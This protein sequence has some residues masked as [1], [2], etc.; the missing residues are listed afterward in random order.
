[1]IVERNPPLSRD[2]LNE[3]QLQMLKQ[4]EI[5]GLL[6]L[7]TEQCDG[8]LSLRYTLTGSKMLSEAIRVSNWS[9]TEMM[10]AL[11]RLAEVLEECRLYLLDADRIR[12]LD[13]FIFIGD[14]WQDLRFTYIPIDMPTL[15]RADDLERLVIRWMMKVKQPDGTVMQ[16][17]LRLVATTGFVPRMLI[18]Y[19]RQYLA[20]SLDSRD[21]VQNHSSIPSI[22]A[23]PVVSTSNI[24]EDEPMHS[25]VKASFSWNILQPPSGDP[26]LLSDLWG[27]D[28]DANSSHGTEHDGDSM[29]SSRLRIVAVCIALLL[30][31][32]AWKFIY[33]G[34]PNEQK[35]LYSVCLT[36]AAGAGVVYLWNGLPNWGTG[37]KRVQVHVD[38]LDKQELYA[39]PEDDAKT[40]NER[41]FVQ[42]RFLNRF[43]QQVNHL[44]PARVTFAYSHSQESDPEST[45]PAETT[46]LTSPPDQTTLLEQKNTSQ[47]VDYYLVWE[48]N[49]TDSRI[50]LQGS[51]LVIG[52][53]QETSQHV[54]ETMGI[55]RA[56]VELV[57]VS[58]QWKVKDLGSRNG[59]IL[60][61]KTMV[62]YE[63]YSLQ[64]GDCIW[65]GKSYYRFHQGG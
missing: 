29:E 21:G 4:C 45:F 48:S 38:A 59:S 33:L 60:N 58:E 61:D 44:P 65:L 22:L 52:R 57:R 2:E 19:A 8:Q 56:H 37:R 42:P 13:D 34:E 64:S 35:L 14:D 63:L 40:E 6:P 28:S 1:M 62:P 30:T 16:Q 20:R 43:A 18:H 55:S 31:A 11:C 32:A 26:H 27:D 47:A 51:S 54:D 17:V 3:M 53:S 49:G 24:R 9:M 50:P 39:E 23:M 41:G 15:H 7:E 5:P 12:L 36:L 10:G 25:P 46:W